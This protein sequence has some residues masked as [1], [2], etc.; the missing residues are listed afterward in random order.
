MLFAIKMQRVLYT[1]LVLSTVSCSTV[2]RINSNNK[3]TSRIVSSLL[4]D[5][6]N[7]YYLQSTYS[8]SSVIWT[9][10]EDGIEIYR[11]HSGKLLSQKHIKTDEC[12]DALFLNM[13]D[14]VELDDYLELDGDILGVQTWKM[15]QEY[16]VCFDCILNGPLHSK[17]LNLLIHDII[18][19]ELWPL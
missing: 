11:L 9:Y 14:L 10:G 6:G 15:K 16:P 7:V 17:R 13:E 5:N 18:N 19:Y 3:A 8:K 2:Y 4:E 12:N 1:I